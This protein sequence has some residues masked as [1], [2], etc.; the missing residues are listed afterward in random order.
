MIILQVCSKFKIQEHQYNR[1]Q[2]KCSISLT[3]IWAQKSVWYSG[4]W[5]FYLT[6]ENYFK[7]LQWALQ[8]LDK[9]ILGTHWNNGRVSVWTACKKDQRKSLKWLYPTIE[10][11][12][13][14]WRAIWNSLHDLRCKANW[15]LKWNDQLVSQE[16]QL[17]GLRP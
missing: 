6:L 15:P 16:E 5:W 11:S 3:F 7:S 13:I 4:R 9:I 14:S 2:S 12:R 1:T 17:K 8:K 10:S